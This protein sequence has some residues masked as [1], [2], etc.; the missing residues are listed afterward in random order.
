LRNG[1]VE[2]VSYNKDLVNNAN[3]WS[4]WTSTSPADPFPYTE[5]LKYDVNSTQQLWYQL[6]EPP[7]Y[8][9]EDRSGNANH[10]TSMSFPVADNVSVSLESA[11]ATGDLPVPDVSAAAQPSL[12]GSIANM[13]DNADGDPKFAYGEPVNT[14][15]WM[16]DLFGN[17]SAQMGMEDDVLVAVM[18]LFVSVVLG[19]GAYLATGNPIIT[20]VGSG[21][22][23]FIGVTLGVLG[24]W[25]IIVFVLVGVATV[26]ISRSI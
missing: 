19:L 14:P 18:L 3:V 25:T 9:F 16:T 22:G 2:S 15:G 1:T 17:T 11:E 10:S 7:T 8:R 26:G 4:F 21:I 5:Y 20:I 13:G 6:N 23:I 24:A 12:L